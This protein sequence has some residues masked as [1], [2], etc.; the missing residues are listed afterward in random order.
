MQS[1]GELRASSDQMLDMLA[2]LVGIESFKRT[3][4]PGSPG[5]VGQAEDAERLS[6]LVFR[7]SQLQLD[8][9]RQAVG[10]AERGELSRRSLE[11]IPPRRLDQI[12]TEWREAQLRLEIATPGSPEAATASNDVERLREEYRAAQE[13]R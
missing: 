1:E 9:A 7:W 3:L 13:R 12:L 5:F 10:A 2:R 11:D 8:L 4:P 6:R